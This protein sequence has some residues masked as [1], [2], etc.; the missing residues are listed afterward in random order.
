[1]T[2]GGDPVPILELTDEQVVELVKQLSPERQRAAPSSLAAAPRKGATSGYGLR[3][4][5]CDEFA[6]SAAWCGTR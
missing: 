4:G 3:K 6:P 2:Y 1:M 5:N